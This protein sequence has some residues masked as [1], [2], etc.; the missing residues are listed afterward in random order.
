MQ[1]P[2]WFKINR[3]VFGELTENIF[4]NQDNNGFKFTINRKTYDLENAKKFWTKVIT[5][6][7]I[8]KNEAKELH[9][10][11]IQK[12]IDALKKIKK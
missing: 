11:L 12:E 7:K 1:K 3:K 2:L 8:T 10:E 4:N 5:T 9:N 6:H